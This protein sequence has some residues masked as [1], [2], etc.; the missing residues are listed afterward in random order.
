MRQ[1]FKSIPLGHIDFSRYV[2]TSFLI[3]VFLSPIMLAFCVL[4]SWQSVSIK[5]EGG[6]TTVYDFY[7]EYVSVTHN[8]THVDITQYEDTSLSHVNALIRDCLGLAVAGWVF[9]MLHVFVVAGGLIINRYNTKRY[10]TS[11]ATLVFM[12]LRKLMFLGTLTLSVVLI[13]LS[14]LIFLS[15]PKALQ[16]DNNCYGFSPSVCGKFLGS[17]N[18]YSWGPEFAWSFPLIYLVLLVLVWLAL[19]FAENWKNDILIKDYTES[20]VESY[21]TDL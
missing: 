10:T 19:C 18:N 13:A 11:Y 21:D 1:G 7:Y 12:Q 4:S 17:D 15:F 2:A 3:C 8:G 5:G 9:S 16:K 20:L 14:T 6:S